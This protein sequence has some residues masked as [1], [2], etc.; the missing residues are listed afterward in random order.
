MLE[1]REDQIF[2]ALIMV[3]HIILIPA[4]HMIGVQMKCSF[5]KIKSVVFSE[6]FVDENWCIY[7][8]KK[9][10]LMSVSYVY[11]GSKDKS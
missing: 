3:C 4:I 5:S 2:H 6:T 10:Y 8:N 1:K 7:A 9:F 11:G